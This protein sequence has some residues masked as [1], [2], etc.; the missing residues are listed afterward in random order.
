MVH[1]KTLHEKVEHFRHDTKNHRTVSYLYISQAVLHFLVSIVA[2]GV[3]AAHYKYID[4][5]VNCNTDELI[6]V[7][8]KFFRCYDALASFYE[9]A[10]RCFLVFLAVYLFM[11]ICKL[12]WIKL[13]FA[14]TLTEKKHICI[15][16]AYIFDAHDSLSATPY[17]FV[18]ADDD[19]AFLLHLLNQ[20]NK[21]LINRFSVFLSPMTKEE[22]EEFISL[23]S[24][25]DNAEEV[26]HT[27]PREKVRMYSE[28]TV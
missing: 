2:L 27:G 9:K 11:C 1:A 22:K 25:S 21:F 26:T 3:D 13:T 19:L 7:D 10:L 5:V 4:S 24:L 20:C 18:C 17:R 12:I 8:H 15:R 16:I 23:W 14:F 28:T 6:S